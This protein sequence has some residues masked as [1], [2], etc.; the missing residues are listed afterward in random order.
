MK[1]SGIDRSDTTD[2][3]DLRQLPR[4]PVCLNAAHTS[5]LTCFRNK[6]TLRQDR[7]RRNFIISHTAKLSAAALLSGTYLP[8]MP[9]VSDHCVFR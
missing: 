6:E 4:H 7:S 1:R 8:D 9:T 5:L 2:H 3:K